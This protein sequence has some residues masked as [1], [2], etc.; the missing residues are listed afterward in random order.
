MVPTDVFNV[1][2]TN[3]YPKSSESVDELQ[4]GCTGQAD[5]LMNLRISIGIL[6]GFFN[7]PFGKYQ[8]VVLSL[9]DPSTT[10][11]ASQVVP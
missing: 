3:T 10:R 1:E 9:W 7:V 5:L 11:Y 2:L 6:L 8:Y 4:A